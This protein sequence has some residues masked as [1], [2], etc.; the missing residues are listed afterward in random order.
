MPRSLFQFILLVAPGLGHR[1][2]GRLPLDCVRAK[3]L[4]S[5]PTLWTVP[6]QA[7]LSMGFSSREYCS[8]LPCPPT[9]DLPNTGIEPVSLESPALEGGF[10]TTRATWEA[11]PF[12]WGV[13]KWS[14]VTE[15]LDWPQFQVTGQSSQNKVTRSPQREAPAFKTWSRNPSP[16]TSEPG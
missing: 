14:F 9:R 5:C 4:Q 8:G 16:R 7:P 2:A 13:G 1:H 12:G 3:L 11:P 10:F 6:W 15:V